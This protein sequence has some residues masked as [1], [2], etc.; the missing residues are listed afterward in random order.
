[1]VTMFS[2][3]LLTG[4]EGGLV[5]TTFD[6]TL[7]R[8]IS[9]QDFLYRD[10]I[11]FTF[12]E[13]ERSFICGHCGARFVS[14]TCTSGKNRIMKHLKTAHTLGKHGEAYLFYS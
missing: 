2:Q 6:P 13:D 12:Y 10:S 7:V 8:E 3:F 5:S 14:H 9:P 1:M 4:P 11:P